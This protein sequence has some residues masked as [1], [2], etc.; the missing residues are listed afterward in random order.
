MHHP[1]MAAVPHA[2]AAA[3]ADVHLQGRGRVCAAAELRRACVVPSA[4]H[5]F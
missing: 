2:L 3:V 5:L 1:Q 4:F